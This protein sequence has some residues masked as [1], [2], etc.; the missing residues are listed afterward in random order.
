MIPT[1]GSYDPLWQSSIP[2]L[3]H[4]FRTPCV[5]HNFLPALHDRSAGTNGAGSAVTRV[6]RGWPFRKRLCCR[7]ISRYQQ[8]RSINAA[9]G[10]AAGRANS[11][12]EQG[13]G[14]GSRGGSHSCT[15]LETGPMSASATVPPCASRRCVRNSDL[16]RRGGGGGTVQPLLCARPQRLASIAATA[17]IAPGA[18]PLRMQSMTDM[19]ECQG[20]CP[21]D[22]CTI[23]PPARRP[24]LLQSPFAVPALH[25]LFTCCD[26]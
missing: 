20:A 7:E 19:R 12:P 24:A 21:A 2:P 15:A 11:E 6:T 13:G 14:G 17:A 8:L 22:T 18:T 10:A 25:D 23:S 26:G 4:I 5:I 9:S 16:I 3:V 1:R